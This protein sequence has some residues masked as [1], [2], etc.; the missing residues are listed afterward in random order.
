MAAA[1]S[2]R[3]L[4]PAVAAEVREALAHRC[5]AGQDFEAAWAAVLRGLTPSQRDDL[6]LNAW[7]WRQAYL[8]R[9]GT[10]IAALVDVLAERQWR[11]R[12]GLAPAETNSA[13]PRTLVAPS[14]TLLCHGIHRKHYP[15]PRRT[16]LS[17]PGDVRA[18]LER[19]GIQHRRTLSLE[20]TTA[21]ERH[22]AEPPHFRRT[23]DGCTA[24]ARTARRP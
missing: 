20:A 1:G 9:G 19:A 8:R 21:I 23:A 7:D 18:R 17:L 4:S 11:E 12:A 6:W 10:G 2:A 5:A 14:A 15:A 3:V 16:V 13:T 24:G 22:I